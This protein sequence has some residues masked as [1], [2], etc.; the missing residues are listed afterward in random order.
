MPESDLKALIKGM[1]PSLSGAEYYFG[2][3]DE[4]MLMGLAD[5]LDYIK[6]IFKEGEGLS[7]IFSGEAKEEI[8]QLTEKKVEGPSPSS[9]WA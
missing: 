1:K 3:F 4:G 8:S 2:S 6:G 7:V 9:P 5:Y